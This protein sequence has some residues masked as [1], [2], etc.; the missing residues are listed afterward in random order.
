MN[1]LIIEDDITSAKVLSRILATYGNIT[2]A[3]DGRHGISIFKESVKSKTLFSFVF[4]DIMMPE[5]DGQEVLKEIRKTESENGILGFDAAK[6]VMTSALD[7]NKNIMQAFRSQCE[8]YLVKPL[9]KDKV[10]Q[11]IERLLTNSR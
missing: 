1:I 10:H 9:I 5:I 4:L 7:D 8:G 2:I 6:I 3:T 11:E